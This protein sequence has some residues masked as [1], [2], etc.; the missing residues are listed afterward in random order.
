MAQEKEREETLIP[1]T[2]YLAS[3]VHIGTQ[4][5]T[6]DMKRFIYQARPDGL[7][8]LD[9]KLMDERLRIAA[10]F[11]A[12]YK[13]SSILLVSAREYGHHPVSTFAKVT[14]T[15]SIVGRFIPGTLTNPQSKHFIEPAIIVLNDPMTD[16]QALKEAV[17]TGIPIIAL[18][19]TNNSTNEVDLIIPTNNKGRKALA[20]VYWLLARE[21]LRE[22]ARKEDKE[23]EFKFD[24]K[25]EDFESEI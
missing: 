8:L 11:L 16:E 22:L 4:Q 19:D 3:G 2:D 21:M 1:G 17:K 14:G 6:G 10:R 12:N 24:Y 18:C 5:K 25:E 15:Q 20:T 23:A 9:I 13:P 7:Y